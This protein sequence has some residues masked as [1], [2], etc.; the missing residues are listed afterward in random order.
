VLFVAGFAHPPNADAACWLVERIM[1]SV[2]KRAS[3]VH[4][5]L[6]GSNPPPQVM[7]LA[8][9]RVTVTGFVPDEELARRYAQARVA[10]APLRYGAGVK[11]KVVEAMRF[12]LP[13][14]TTSVGA[15]G[16]AAAGDAIVVADEP[17]LFAEAVVDLLHDD[18]RWR[19]ISAAELAFAREKFSVEAMRRVFAEHIAFG[20]KE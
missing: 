20:R 7:A 10:V 14:V 18:E 13:I 12:G 8:G 6:V 9:P 17:L 11:G 1:P 5:Y 16:L 3:D 2:W 15:Q 19:K 4:L